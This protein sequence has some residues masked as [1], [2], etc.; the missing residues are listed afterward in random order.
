M[1]LVYLKN[2]TTLEL[3]SEKCIGCRK[4]TQVCPH[5]VFVVES[6]KS[7]IVAKDS[8]M[9]CGACALNCPSGALSVDS[10]VG[11]AAAIIKGAIRGTEPDCDCC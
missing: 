3:D 5:A 1:S 4:C 6:R 10:G 2:V 7:R 9:E 8:C 11:C